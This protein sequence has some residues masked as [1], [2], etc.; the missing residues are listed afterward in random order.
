MTQA[1]RA[2]AIRVLKDERDA[3]LR[4]LKEQRAA[5]QHWKEKKCGLLAYGPLEPYWV[6]F[7]VQESNFS[8]GG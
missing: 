3:S 5:E 2:A 8:S 4:M 6:I 7:Y 1:E